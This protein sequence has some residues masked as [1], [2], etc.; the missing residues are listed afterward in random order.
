MFYTY[1]L[2]KK[3]TQPIS[4]IPIPIIQEIERKTIKKM[5]IITRVQHPTRCSSCN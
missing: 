4:I 5:D 1:S 2:Y 3:K